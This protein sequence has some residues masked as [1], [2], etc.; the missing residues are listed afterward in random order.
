MIIVNF[1][2][3]VVGEKA[4]ELAS[5]I[6]KVS[7]KSGVRIVSAVSVA[8]YVSCQETGAECWTQKYE[9]QLENVDGI[10]L[11]HSDYKVEWQELDRQ[12]RMNRSSEICVCCET[13]KEGIRL[14]DLRAD[15]LAYEPK[16]LIGNKEKSVST[17]Q[18]ETIKQLVEAIQIPVLVGAGIHNKE[19][20][21]IALRL[22]AKGIL[23]ATDVVKASD[24]EKELR[25]LVSAFG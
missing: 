20:V 25:E 2:W 6:R 16:E 14:A 8:D 22:G 5:L 1:K 7:D 10:I 4:V 19:D 23:V 3:F 21:Q 24:P 18:P 17:E 15:W 12:I 11:N 13:F 9:P